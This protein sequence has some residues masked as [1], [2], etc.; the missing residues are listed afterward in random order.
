[1]T[2]S[3]PVRD[4]AAHIDAAGAEAPL[5]KLEDFLPHRLNVLS[6]LVSQALTR[7]Y[8]RYGI[9][10]PEWRVLVT[11]GENG[12]MTGKAVGAHTH[13]HKTKVS[14][15]VAQLEQRKFLS[16]RANRADLRESFLSLTPAGREVYEE[17]APTA[18][19]FMDRLAEVVAPA[20]RPAFDRAMK[21]LTQRSAELVAEIE[22]DN[23]DGKA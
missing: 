4:N 6:S 2:N 17:L 16:R 22:S 12:V 18:H 9:G 13:M 7:V 11:L 14:R 15:A 23:T 1:M 3:G 20:D 21:Q 5:L 19:A 10:I 8:G